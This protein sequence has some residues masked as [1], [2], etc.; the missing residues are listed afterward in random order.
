MPNLKIEVTDV[1]PCTKKLAIELPASQHRKELEKAY[2]TLNKKVQVQ[3]FRQGKAPIKVL[4]RYYKDRVETEVL[5]KLV[6][7]SFQEA[8]QQED[9][10]TVGQPKLENFQAEEGNPVKLMLTVEVKPEIDQVNF[11]NL[12]FKKVVRKIIPEDVDKEMETLREKFA[13]LVEKPDGS[14]DKGDYAIIDYQLFIEGKPAPVEQKE[15]VTLAVGEDGLDEDIER[16]LLGMAKGEEKDIKLSYP[17]DYARKELAG[18]EATF[19]VKAQAV[20]TKVLP[21]LDDDFARR[22]GDYDTLQELKEDL[23]ARMEEY[24]EQQATKKLQDEI[25]SKLV[26]INPVQAP[27]SMIEEEINLRLFHMQNQLQRQG[28]KLNLSGKELEEWR[29]KIREDA[30]NNVKT[31]LILE[32]IAQLKGFEVS[33]EEL[34]EELKKMVEGAAHDIQARKKQ[35]QESGSLPALKESLLR[36]KALNNIMTGYKIEETTVES[37]GNDAQQQGDLINRQEPN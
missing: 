27:S 11:E 33:D 9:L 22:I 25:T 8:V 5:Q 13:E 16:Q 14:I 26:E 23:K 19:K 37:N 17:E 18:K 12:E 32:K 2:R 15:N 35:M 34:E 30:I 28:L 3:G 6:S 4:E 29:G 1:D 20:K 21:P 10:R 7:E 24:E 31:N 36:E